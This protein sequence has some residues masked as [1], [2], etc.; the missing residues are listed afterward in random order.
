MNWKNL[1]TA[2]VLFWVGFCFSQKPL[3]STNLQK[4][5]PI[6]FGEIFGGGTAGTPNG[7]TLGATLNYQH[8][9]DVFTIRGVSKLK[10]DTKA[11]YDGWFLIIPVFDLYEEFSEV[12]LLYG[13]RY[14]LS[15]SSSLSISGGIAFNTYRT[16]NQNYE[17][18][19]QKNIGFPM[20][21]NWKLFKAKK[22]RYRI[23]YGLVPVGKPTAFG[24][25][26]GLKLYANLSKKSYI[27][28]GISLGLGTH[29]QY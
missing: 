19:K 18:I 12:S 17:E 11:F 7:F 2:V 3:D 24:R 23:L 28:L 9:K 13:K 5:N 15:E 22:S 16:R 1:L 27:G 29:K 26:F 21:V 10:T 14:L 6:I 8:Q 25:S 20:E 4:T